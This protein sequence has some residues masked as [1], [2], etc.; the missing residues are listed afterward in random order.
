MVT[1]RVRRVAAPRPGKNVAFAGAATLPDVQV[2]E[3]AL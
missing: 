3:Q 2:G 1:F